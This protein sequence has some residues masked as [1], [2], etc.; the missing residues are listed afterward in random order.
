MN[1][2]K[3]LMIGGASA[4][5][6]LVMIGTAQATVVTSSGAS[7]TSTISAESTNSVFHGSFLSVPCTKAIIVWKVESHGAGTTA[8][9]KVSSLSFSGCK[10]PV[11]VKKAGSVSKHATSSGNAT[12]TGSGQEIAIHTS[13][14]ECVATTNATHLGVVTGGVPAILPDNTRVVPRTGGS[15][16]CGSS[17][18]WT[19][20]FT[21]TTPSSLS[22]D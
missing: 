2:L 17:I 21:V 3:S 18:Q 19:G 9:G 20:A 5:A 11:T 14:G 15:F 6:F 22:F 13:I 16:F 7:Y 4:V 10:Y 12:M 1:K 8:E